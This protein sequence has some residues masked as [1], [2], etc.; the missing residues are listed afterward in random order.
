MVNTP[1]SYSEVP[2][3]KTTKHLSQDSLSLGRDLSPGPPKYEAGVLTFEQ[4]V[5]FGTFN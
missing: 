5:R 1:A 3:F 4:D 2:R